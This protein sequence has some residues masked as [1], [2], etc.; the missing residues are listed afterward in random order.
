MYHLGDILDKE[1]TH[2][3]N[4]TLGN[5]RSAFSKPLIEKISFFLICQDTVLYHLG[6]VLDQ[7]LT[8]RLNNTLGNLCTIAKNR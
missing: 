6:Y 2:R 5:R 8:D 1:L 3:L 7:K 4:N